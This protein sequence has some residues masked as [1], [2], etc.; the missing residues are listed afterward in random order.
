MHAFDVDTAVRSVGPGEVEGDMHAHWWVQRGPNGG[1]VAAQMLRAMVAA[2][3]DPSRHARS[4]TLHFVAPPELRPVRIVSEVVRSGRSLTSVSARMVQD[5]KVCALALGA[6]STSRPS[7][8][9]DA[10]ELPAW[11]PL[12]EVP[13]FERG[14]DVPPVVS[15]YEVRNTSGAPFG[16][17]EPRTGGWIAMTGANRPLDEVAIAAISDAWL[18]AIYAHVTAPSFAVP[19]VDLTVHFRSP[20]P[21]GL[22]HCGVEFRSRLAADGF[23]EEDGE[24]WSPDGR[25]LVQSR[26]LSVMAG[27]GPRL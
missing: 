9:M 23:V 12:E 20:I 25:L 6:F 13:V 3:G 14:D 18:P 16:G 5:G 2:H 27:P 4:L 1:F 24:L 8:E 7:F 15:N 10:V 11:P 26:Q 22:L 17:G 19:T 21:D